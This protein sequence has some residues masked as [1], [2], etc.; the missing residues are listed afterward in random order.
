MPENNWT[1]TDVAKRFEEAVRT[2]RRL[3][4]VR[5]QGYVNL[6]PPIFYTARELWEMD[7]TPIRLGPPSAAAITRMEKTL[8]WI[9]WVDVEERHLIWL[10]AHGVRW[11]KIGVRLGLHP[12]TA[13]RHWVIALL[14]IAGELDRTHIPNPA[15]S[16]HY[17]A[18]R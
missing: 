6:W 3:P 18:P 10:R 2:L 4:P 13:W 12:K 8:P 1:A 17:D 5:V 7:K 15:P 16:Q 9:C 11:K 14:K